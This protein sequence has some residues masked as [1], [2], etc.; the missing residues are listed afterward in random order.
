LDFLTYLPEKTS[1]KNIQKS[2]ILANFRGGGGLFWSLLL[3]KVKKNVYQNKR[4][5]ILYSLYVI[6]KFK[7]MT[8]FI[9]K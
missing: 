7:T 6:E 4:I 5:F 8:N 3:K 9:L 1:K 2:Y